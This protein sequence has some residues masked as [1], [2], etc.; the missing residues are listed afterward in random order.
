MCHYLGTRRAGGRQARGREC[1]SIQNSVCIQ[2]PFLSSSG[3]AD[4]HIFTHLLPTRLYISFVSCHTPDSDLTMTGT[5]FLSLSLLLSL[6]PSLPPSL[7]ASQLRARSR[8][9][10]VSL[11]CSLPTGFNQSTACDLQTNLSIF[12]HQ[13]CCKPPLMMSRVRSRDGCKYLYGP[14]PGPGRGHAGRGR[15]RAR[16]A[17][18]TRLPRRYG[19][20]A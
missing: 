13:Q 7:P 9:L 19:A 6:P 2:P 20:G 10:S 1:P 16:G 5:T 3:P 8:L 14:N 15:R 18:R 11:H 17:Y 12:S 4:A